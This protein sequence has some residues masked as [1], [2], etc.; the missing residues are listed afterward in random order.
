MDVIVSEHRSYGGFPPLVFELAGLEELVLDHQAISHVP[1]EIRHLHNL[2]TLSLDYC[3]LLESLDGSLGLLP[4]LTSK[5][6]LLPMD[7]IFPLIFCHSYILPWLHVAIVRYSETSLYRTPLRP[8]SNV[9]YIGVFGQGGFQI[10]LVSCCFTGII[11]F[12]LCKL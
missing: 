8:K 2:R 9:R 4:K 5:S 11:L 7:G 1:A 12:C 3:P 6:S 10:N